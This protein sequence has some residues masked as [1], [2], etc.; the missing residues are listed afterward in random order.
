MKRKNTKLSKL[1]ENS[2]VGFIE[3]VDKNPT[4]EHIGR[5]KIRVYG[6]YGDKNSSLGKIP[7]EDIPWAYPYLGLSFGSDKGSGVF[8]TPKNGT[9][10]R[11]IF[12]GDQYHPYY[13]AVEEI[14]KKVKELAISDYEGF[15]SLLFDED[16]DVKIYHSKKTGLLLD[17]KGS[18]F[19]ILPDNSILINLK[20]STSVIEL[21]G[22]DIDITS[23]NSIN[24]SSNNNITF[25]S[26]KI[27]VNGVGTDVGANPIYAS[28]NGEQ[29]MILFSILATAIDAKYPL[30]PGSASGVVQSMKELILSKTVKVSP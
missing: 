7:T 15:H 22:N 28:M 9:P 11:V 16:Q 6:V 29:A 24:A 2:F 18:F 1:L 12:D 8:S 14:S 25:N 21:K 23:K 20:D 17:L 26:N 30:T 5:C 3:D 10:V 27:H 19:N 13:I 4:E